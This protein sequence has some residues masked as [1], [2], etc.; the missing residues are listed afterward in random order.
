MHVKMT[1]MLKFILLCPNVY[2]YMHMSMHSVCHWFY[3]LLLANNAVSDKSVNLAL[4]CVYS[5]KWRELIAYLTTFQCGLGGWVHAT[6]G[7]SGFAI[8]CTLAYTIFPHADHYHIMRIEDTCLER[9]CSSRLKHNIIPKHLCFSPWRHGYSAN[10]FHSLTL[11][12]A[13]ISPLY[14]AT[15]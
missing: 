13:H 4:L 8:Q 7:L 14:L 12:S 6:Q 9:V 2:I 11:S 10:D 15:L 3:H 1:G 5:A